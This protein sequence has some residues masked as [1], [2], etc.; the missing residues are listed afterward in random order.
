MLTVSATAILWDFDKLQQLLRGAEAGA[1]D[2]SGVNGPALF[3]L[4][5]TLF[6]LEAFHARHGKLVYSGN[7]VSLGI[8]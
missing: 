2:Q 6:S 7:T 1:E 4:L 5:Q 8:A 3:W